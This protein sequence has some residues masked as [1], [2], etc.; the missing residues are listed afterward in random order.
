MALIAAPRG[1]LDADPRG[2]HVG[3]AVLETPASCTF[4]P[5]YPNRSHYGCEGLSSASRKLR[6]PSTIVAMCCQDGDIDVRSIC[7]RQGADDA[8][9]VLAK[10][11]GGKR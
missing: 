10:Q 2:R 1:S 8:E 9:R 4:C 11:H 5:E 6:G 7:S 3:A